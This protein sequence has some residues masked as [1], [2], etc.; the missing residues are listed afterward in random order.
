[1]NQE[2]DLEYQYQLY[3]KRVA[4]KEDIMPENQKRQLRQAFMG[5]CGQM[6][7]LLRDDVVGLS[8]TDAIK[9]MENMITQVGNYFLK[10]TNKNN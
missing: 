4:L 5:A 9:T 10:A 3:L 7:L 8:E 1:M 6:L 2:F